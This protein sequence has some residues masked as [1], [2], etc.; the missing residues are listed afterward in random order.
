VNEA[1][2]VMYRAS[3]ANADSTV[4]GVGLWR[5]NTLI[6]HTGASV[7]GLGSGAVMQ[8]LGHASLNA[9]GQTFWAGTAG[10]DAALAVAGF[11]RDGVLLA[12]VGSNV[13]DTSG[14]QLA[15]LPIGAP[16]DEAPSFNDQGLLSFKAGLSGTGVTTSTNQGLFI[17]DGQ[18]LLTVVREGQALAGSV[19]VSF[20]SGNLNS[21]GQRAY[22]AQLADGRQGAFVYTPDLRWRNAGSGSWDNAAGWTLGIGPDHLYQVTLDPSA[23]LTVT[24]PRG[25]AHVRALTIGSGSGLATLQLAG[26]SI[27]SASPVQVAARGVLTGSGTVAT[28]VANAGEVRPDNLNLSGGLLNSGLVRGSATGGQR[29][30]T[31]LDNRT[32]GW[33]QVNAGERLLLAVMDSWPTQA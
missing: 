29:L 20:T 12:R 18:D 1:G 16:L 17:T 26:G 19:V 11:W 8:S 31:A 32:A 10:P 28:Q 6:T 30:N 15:S 33:L 27:T 2:Q 4:Q 21:H 13:T 24:G 23:S 5:D 3:Y 14:V 9:S 7:G 25:A 22:T